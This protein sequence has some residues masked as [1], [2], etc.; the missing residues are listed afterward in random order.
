MRPQSLFLLFIFTVIASPQAPSILG[1]GGVKMQGERE[2]VLFTLQPFAAISG[3]YEKGL[4][5]AGLDS[6]GNLINEGTASA[7]ASVGLTGSKAW[8]HSSLGVSF[9]GG[10]PIYTGNQDYYGANRFRYSLAAN[11]NYEKHTSARSGFVFQQALGMGDGS[12][13]VT[14]IAGVG[15]LSE[16]VAI[17]A[18][19]PAYKGAPIEDIY[20]AKSFFGTT[21]ASYIWQKS[22]ALSFRATGNAST[23]YRPKIGLASSY[24][25]TASGDVSYALSRNH[26]VGVDYSY[27]HIGFNRSFGATD[28]HSIGLNYSAR[29]GR[30]WTLALNGGMLRAES[31]RIAVVP[32][33]PYIASILGTS[34][35]LGVAHGVSKGFS[36]GMS[37]ARGFRN[38]QISL[39]ASQGISP[40]NGVYLA[41]KA[42]TGAFAYSYSGIRKWTINSAVI[43]TRYSAL[44]Q[45]SL[46]PYQGYT[47][48]VSTGRQLFKYVSGS[49]SVGLRRYDTGIIKRD[50]YFVAV[51]LS[52]TPR[53]LPVTR[54]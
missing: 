44:L 45:D 43:Y 38:S 15:G 9:G 53:G 27:A 13:S 36:G 48:V 51:G 29:L 19:D 28:V 4:T 26:T 17:N 1:R 3:S 37:L 22:N 33:D 12:F 54:W 40:G 50:S 39:T 42:A 6:N 11:H 23:T 21:S 41:S 32:L 2:R 31:E 30:Y 35:S 7:F 5:P 20:Q 52:F 18:S 47:G 25:A 14:N 34:T 16:M 10:Y 8:R 46:K 24:G 49:A